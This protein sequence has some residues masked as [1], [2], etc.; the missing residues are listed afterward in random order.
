[1]ESQNDDGISATGLYESTFVCVVRISICSPDRHFGKTRPFV[2]FDDFNLRSRENGEV[3][4]MKYTD[5]LF[6]HGFRNRY[7]LRN[8]VNKESSDCK[9]EF[10]QFESQ[11]G[12]PYMKSGVM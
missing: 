4:E 10:E 7:L 6:T 2:A 3:S 5:A 11:R 12:R 9:D 1:L 8:F